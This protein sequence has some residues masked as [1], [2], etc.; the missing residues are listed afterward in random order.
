VNNTLFI[1]GINCGPI[2]SVERLVN[3]DT[4]FRRVADEFGNLGIV[5]SIGT[6][7]ENFT[8]SLCCSENVYEFLRERV[9]RVKQENFKSIANT[10]DKLEFSGYIKSLSV[11]CGMSGVTSVDLDVYVIGR[12]T[13]ESIRDINKMTNF[14]ILE[15]LHRRLELE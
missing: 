8:F 13:C 2:R 3:D 4:Y 9:R 10:G 15:F 11:T 12:V 14:E 1:D 5:K 6:T 7:S